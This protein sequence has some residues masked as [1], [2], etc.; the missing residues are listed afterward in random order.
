[1]SFIN[2][3]NKLSMP[4]WLKTKSTCNLIGEASLDCAPSSK[5]EKTFTEP[6]NDAIIAE[7]AA[8]PKNEA[9]SQRVRTTSKGC[10]H[11]KEEQGH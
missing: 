7:E 10:Q 4:S 5:L 11:T 3:E 9:E 6:G 1:M 8:N 2:L